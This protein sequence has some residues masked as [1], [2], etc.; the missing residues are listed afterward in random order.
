MVYY[1]F[2]YYSN[3]AIASDLFIDEETLLFHIKV[4][5]TED[6]GGTVHEESITS[7]IYDSEEEMS[8]CE[9]TGIAWNRDIE[10]NIFY[11]K[12]IEKIEWN[13]EDAKLISA[14][15]IKEFWQNCQSTDNITSENTFDDGGGIIYSRITFKND[16]TPLI[17]AQYNI[18]NGY[19]AHPIRLET[20]KSVSH[21]WEYI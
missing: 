3:D 12:P 14:K 7:K 19:Y 4:N 16:P 11:R 20:K 13:C 5:W 17:I 6:N 18:H 8:C 10:N 2:V 21:Q 9:K 15:E 1:A